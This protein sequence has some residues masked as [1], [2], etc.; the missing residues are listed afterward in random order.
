MADV[1]VKVNK[2]LRNGQA[3]G[4]GTT[5]LNNWS[6]A[7]GNMTTGNTYLIPFAEDDKLGFFLSWNACETDTCYTIGVK[8]YLGDSWRSGAGGATTLKTTDTTPLAFEPFVIYTTSSGRIEFGPFG[9]F[10]S[11]KFG[12][13]STTTSYGAELNEQY[14][15]VGFIDSSSSG[16]GFTTATS[17]GA[18][19]T[20]ALDAPIIRAFVWP[21]VVYS[22]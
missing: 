12:T 20:V 4:F 13:L 7:I 10:E 1:A 18:A 21:S 2:M 9:P 8:V 17:T 22:S 15:K 5:A 14:L 19:A 6:T 11:A 3:A 16:G